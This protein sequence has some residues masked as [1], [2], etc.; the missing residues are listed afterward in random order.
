MWWE[1]TL[2]FSE[3]ST[4][5][6]KDINHYQLLFFTQE[7]FLCLYISTELNVAAGNVRPEPLLWCSVHRQCSNTQQKVL[8]FFFATLMLQYTVTSFVSCERDHGRRTKQSLERILLSCVSKNTQFVF[9]IKKCNC[10][11]SLQYFCPV[12]LRRGRRRN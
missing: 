1:E 12:S 3:W 11:C 4:W 5:S 10:C 7:L 2:V 8:R 9:K 6:K